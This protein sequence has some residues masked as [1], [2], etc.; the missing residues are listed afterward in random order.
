[1][2]SLTNAQ[3]RYLA[4]A[5]LCVDVEPKID[6]E[7]FAVLAGSKT[8]NSARE[9]LRVT[10]KKL[11]LEYASVSTD[12]TVAPPN[13]PAAATKTFKKK[14]TPKTKSTG[15]AKGGKKRKIT[16]DSDEESDAGDDTPIKKKNV[17]KKEPVDED[18][19]ADAGAGAEADAED[20]EV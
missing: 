13:T 1:M 19:D 20:A 14:A 10:K 6:Y 18:S 15:K 17:V 9:M 8:A 7:R 12:G 3:N 16:N 4:L 5:W 11:H 2:T